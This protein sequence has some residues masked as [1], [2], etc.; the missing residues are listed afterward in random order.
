MG[1]VDEVDEN[2]EG[3]K[4][5]EESARGTAMTQRSKVVGGGL[6]FHLRKTIVCWR[7]NYSH[8]IF[9]CCR[10]LCLSDEHYLV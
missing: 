2:H 10:S 1:E 7:N 3:E 4:G 5:M 9:A 6:T 8:R